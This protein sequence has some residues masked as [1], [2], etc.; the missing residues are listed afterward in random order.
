MR[1][2][3]MAAGG[4][5]GHQ[6][7][8]VYLCST[9]RNRTCVCELINATIAVGKD[10]ARSVRCSARSSPIFDSSASLR[11]ADTREERRK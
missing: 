5:N 7:G 10:Q 4:R 3:T 9:P 11:K 8:T 2:L 6:R 1:D